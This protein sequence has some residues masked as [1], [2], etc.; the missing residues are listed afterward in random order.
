MIKSEK[1]LPAGGDGVSAAGVKEVFSLP[2]AEPESYSPLTLAY[3]GDS[4][5]E[6]IIRSLVVG[7]GNTSPNRLNQKASN[8]SKASSQSQIA[9][10]IRDLLTDEEEA[11]FRRGRNAHSATMAKN[12]S[13][14]DYRRATGLEALCGYLYLKGETRRLMELLEKGLAGPEENTNGLS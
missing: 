11:V 3:L 2:G 7:K 10:S 5:Y 9:N 6:L 12:A 14:S 13:M 1:D 4:V 8:L